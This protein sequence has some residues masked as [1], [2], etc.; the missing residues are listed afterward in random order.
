MDEDMYGHPALGIILGV[1][2][3]NGGRHYVVDHC[4]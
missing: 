4:I 2:F 3:A 1:G